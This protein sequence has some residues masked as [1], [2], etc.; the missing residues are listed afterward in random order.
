VIAS[1]TPPDGAGHRGTTDR[2]S[3]LIDR[4]R[5]NYEFGGGWICSC[6]EFLSQDSC[7]HTREA[8]GRRVAQL[9]IAHRLEQRRSEFAER[10]VR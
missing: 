1:R 4:F 6:R 8:A 5:V 2:A 9:E 10:L 7:K 3:Y